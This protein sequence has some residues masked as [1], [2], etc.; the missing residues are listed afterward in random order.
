M[1]IAMTQ[2]KIDVEIQMADFDDEYRAVTFLF[3]NFP[4]KVEEPE[5]ENSKSKLPP[6]ELIEDHFEEIAAIIQGSRLSKNDCIKTINDKFP[7][8]TKT[9]IEAFFRV[10]VQ[11]DKMEKTEIQKE[12]SK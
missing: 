2:Q 7:T 5:T 3:E 8:I 9:S 10:C 1:R 12:L 4:L 6:R 11:K